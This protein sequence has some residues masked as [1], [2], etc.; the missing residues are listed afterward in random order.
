MS[1]LMSALQLVCYSAERRQ[2]AQG[3]H[4]TSQQMTEGRVAGSGRSVPMSQSRNRLIAGDGIF[5]GVGVEQRPVPDIRV[6]C[7]MQN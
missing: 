4:A 3:G 7:L 1:V 2:L 6:V 5:A